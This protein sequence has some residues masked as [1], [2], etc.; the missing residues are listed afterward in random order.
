M[1]P[2]DS[3]ALAPPVTGTAAARD[4]GIPRLEVRGLSKTFSGVTVLDDARL[5][6]QPDPF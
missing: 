4:S 2:D 3:P 5:S 6:L 1:S